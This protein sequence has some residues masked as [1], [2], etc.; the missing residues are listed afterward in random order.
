MLF[1]FFEIGPCVFWQPFLLNDKGYAANP[2]S[3]SFCSSVLIY[4][5]YKKWAGQYM[6]V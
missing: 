1:S 3:E 6:S 5:Y 2:P 4:L